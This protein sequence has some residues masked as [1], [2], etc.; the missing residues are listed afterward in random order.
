MGTKSEESNQRIALYPGTFDALTYGHLDLIERACR[1]FEKVIVGVAYNE[2]KEALFTPE[3]RVEMIKEATIH[4]NNIEVV[5]FSS[6][7]VEFA[8]KI[9]ASFIIRGLRAISDFEY[10]L[11]MALINRELNPD[12]E[13]IFLAP[14]TNYIFLSSRAVKEVLKFNGDISG[15]APENVQKK[16]RE[17]FLKNKLYIC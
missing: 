5:H 10:E 9:G 14:A 3:E 11:Q 15:M 2:Q 16:M 12:I 7:S 8:K 4:L 6:L 17:K 1:L 13:T